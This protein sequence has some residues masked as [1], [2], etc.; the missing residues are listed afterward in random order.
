MLKLCGVAVSNYYNKVKL[1]LF[2]KGVP[3]EEEIVSPSQ[4]AR[5]SR[6]RW[7]RCRSSR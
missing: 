2:E 1:Q 4:P 3:F 7:A 5:C 6:R